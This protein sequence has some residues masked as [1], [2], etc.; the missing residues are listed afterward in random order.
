MDLSRYL[1]RAG[2]LL[3]HMSADPSAA[4][5]DEAVDAIV[6][7]L[8]QGRSLL[9]CGNGGSAADSMHIAGELMGRFLKNRRALRAIS[10]ASDPALLTAWSND[11]AY[12]SVFARQVEGLG[13]PGGVLWGLST[14]GDSANVVAAFETARAIG[15]TTLAFTGEGGGRLASLSDVLIE[16]PSRSTPEIQQVHVCLYHYV[17]ERVEARCCGEGMG[18]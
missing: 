13:E 9:V 12:E 2:D 8:S 15:M 6:A 7:A 18:S 4:R 10:L 1:D 5:V 16:V 11:F 14:S 17:C 3:K